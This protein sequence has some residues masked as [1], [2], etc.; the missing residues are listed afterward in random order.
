MTQAV[1]TP[2]LEDEADPFGLADEGGPAVLDSPPVPVAADPAPTT[3][4]NNNV[5]TTP[6]PTEAAAPVQESPGGW[7]LRVTPKHTCIKPEID[8]RT[9][10]GSIWQCG[11]CQEYWMVAE[12]R[13]KDAGTKVF[14]KITADKAEKKLAS[15]RS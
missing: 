7:V 14:R 3:V 11:E 10:V 2:G 13:G 8:A 9:F 15:L 12:K 6:A 1:E 4:V 5:T